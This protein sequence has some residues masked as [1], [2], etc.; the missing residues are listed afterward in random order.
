MKKLGKRNYDLISM[1]MN[2]LGFNGPW[3]GL[4]HE[5]RMYVGE[6]DEIIEFLTWLHEIDRPFGREN[7]EQRFAEFKRGDKPPKSWFEVH[8]HFPRKPDRNGICFGEHTHI[9]R[10]SADHTDKLEVAVRLCG[11]LDDPDYIKVIEVN[12][13]Y[14]QEYDLKEMKK[15]VKNNKEEIQKIKFVEMG[16]EYKYEYF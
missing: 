16:S 10:I 15:F 7:Y 11:N 2:T 8:V 6:I 1:S 5:E 14:E 3:D 4:M 12:G 13:T 9:K